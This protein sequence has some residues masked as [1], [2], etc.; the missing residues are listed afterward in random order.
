MVK[1]MTQAREAEYLRANGQRVESMEFE[2]EGAWLV[3]AGDG[4]LRFRLEDVPVLDLDFGEAVELLIK[5]G[6]AQLDAE[7][8]AAEFMDVVST[9]E[10]AKLFARRAKRVG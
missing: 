10:M 7:R 1:A 5:K 6:I 3:D 9:G 8:Y 4:K 2:L